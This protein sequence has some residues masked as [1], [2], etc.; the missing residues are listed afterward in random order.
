MATAASVTQAVRG[1]RAPSRPTRLKIT[2]S[3]LLGLATMLAV[4]AAAFNTANNLLYLL[5]A[6][7]AAVFVVS[8]LLA[9]AALRRV[10]AEV[11]LPAEIRADEPCEAAIRLAHARGATVPGIVVTLEAG[12]LSPEAAAVAALERDEVVTRGLALHLG[13]R[14]AR[15]VRARLTCPFPFGV[16]VASRELPEREVLVLPAPAHGTASP[17]GHDAGSDGEASSR[18]GSGSD[19]LEI[20]DY[21]PGDDARSLDW[22]ST[23]KLSRLM[24]KQHAEEQ[25]REVSLVV[26]PTL[27]RARREEAEAAV[28]WQVSRAAGAA[29]DLERQGWR[30]RLLAPGTEVRGSAR[31]VMRALARLAYR[32]PREGAWQP[33][34]GPT[35]PALT[36]RA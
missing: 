29:L 33:T 12:G 35:G 31:E 27:P 13:R 18:R 32:P 6:L 14:G 5:G 23:A 15:R 21:R 24:V 30:L 7:L 17:H 10:E 22:K 2:R 28:E 8:A 25:V 4:I 9:T 1:E 11:L 3:G 26:D 16:L 34:V 20:R 19:L 36:F